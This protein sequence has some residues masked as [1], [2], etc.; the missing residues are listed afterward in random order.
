M[1]NDLENIA[2]QVAWEIQRYG[3]P[4]TKEIHIRA[5]N[6]KGSIYSGWEHAAAL[7]VLELLPKV[8]I[9]YALM[10]YSNSCKLREGRIHVV[11]EILSEKGALHTDPTIEQYFPNTTSRVFQ[12]EEFPIPLVQGTEMRFSREGEAYF[13]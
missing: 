8:A 3:F 4:L 1:K 6:Y 2:D 5:S 11:S 12:P 7:R 13:A 9:G 10:F